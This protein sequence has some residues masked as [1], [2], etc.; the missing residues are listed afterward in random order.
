LE[1]AQKK[2]VLCHI[3]YLWISLVEFHVIFPEFVDSLEK[4]CFLRKLLLDI[5]SIENVLEVHPL[6]LKGKPFI[7]DISNITKMLLPHFDSSSNFSYEL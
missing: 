2:R 7:N 3:V 4:L 6:A 5:L 1:A